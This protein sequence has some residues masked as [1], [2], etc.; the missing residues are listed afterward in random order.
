MTA[1]ILIR[2][3][4]QRII[5]EKHELKKEHH[6]W[7][8]LKKDAEACRQL[9]ALATQNAQARKQDPG[10][11]AEYAAELQKRGLKKNFWEVASNA[12]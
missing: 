2:F 11:E 1:R 12:A 10:F 5:S 4:A 8:V 6:Y 3:E 9:S 7:D